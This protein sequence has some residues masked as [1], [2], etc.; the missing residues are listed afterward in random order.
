[1]PLRRIKNLYNFEK[2][3]TCLHFYISHTDVKYNA[4][5]CQNIVDGN[6]SCVE[7]L[8][9][10]NLEFLEYKYGRSKLVVNTSDKSNA[11]LPYK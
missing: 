5:A 10:D 2:C 7:F 9:Q 4:S 8:P 1:M 3:R 11:D 6:C